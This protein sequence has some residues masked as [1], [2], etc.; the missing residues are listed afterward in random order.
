[1]T[2]KRDGPLLGP[3]EVNVERADYPRWPEE[4]WFQKQRVEMGEGCTKLASDAQGRSK[5]K[6]K[7]GTVSS[8][9]DGPHQIT[10]YSFS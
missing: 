2:L 1:M 4:I 10:R 7:A 3:A 8:R 6:A 5:E 9:G